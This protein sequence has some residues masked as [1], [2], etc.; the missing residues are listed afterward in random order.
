MASRLVIPFGRVLRPGARGKDVVAVKRAI[1][2]AKSGRL[3]GLTPIFGP[4]FKRELCSFQARHGLKARGAYDL[5][6]HKLLAPHF[7]AYAGFLYLGHVPRKA[8]TKA[9]AREQALRKRIVAAMLVL[10]NHRAAVHY[11]QGSRRMDGVILR[12]HP[13]QFP[14]YADCSSA[15]TWAYY[16]AGAPDPNGANYNGTGYTGTLS[17]RGRKVSLQEA[18]P[19]DLVFYGPGWPW[20][21]VAV[22]IGGGRVLSHGSEAGPYLLPVDYRSDRGEIRSY[23]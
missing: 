1:R 6:T 22:Y 13:P 14:R 18:K 15:A 23:L 7:D 11:T 12:L 3:R 16:A 9:E 10:Y 20:G 8:P 19:G 4:F 2:R 17:R 5:P 21:H